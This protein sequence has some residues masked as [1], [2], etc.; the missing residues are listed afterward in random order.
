MNKDHTIVLFIFFK[1][2]RDARDAAAP[3]SKPIA[4]VTANQ[5]GFYNSKK[6]ITCIVDITETNAYKDTNVPITNR[7]TNLSFIILLFFPNFGFNF[8]PFI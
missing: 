8:I 3:I 6:S 1:I 2:T 4:K 7:F 5:Y